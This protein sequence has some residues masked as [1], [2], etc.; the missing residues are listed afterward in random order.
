MI[1]IVKRSQENKII[2]IGTYLYNIVN[3]FKTPMNIKYHKE[4]KLYFE[5]KI[6]S[7]H[8]NIYR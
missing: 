1:L 4:I 2:N 6:E 7:F 3:R 8:E 5:I